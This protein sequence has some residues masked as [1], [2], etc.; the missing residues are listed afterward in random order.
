MQLEKPTKELIEKYR[1]EFERKNGEEEAAIRE[2]FKI[3]S[4]NKDYKGVLLKSIVINALYGTRIMRID[5][6][7]RHICEV[8]TKGM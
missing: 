4:D 8:F 6:I 2:I 3:F 5:N 7:A 1:G